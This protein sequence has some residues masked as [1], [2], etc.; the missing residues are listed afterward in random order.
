MAE[1]DLTVCSSASALI[2]T[3]RQRYLLQLRSSD[4][5]IWYAGYWGLF[6]GGI[7]PGETPEQTLRRELKEEL[8]F[9]P[10]ALSYFTQVGIDLR[11]VRGTAVRHTYYE[12]AINEDEVEAMHLGEGDA[13]RLFTAA[14]L[15]DE[16]KI[17]G[18]HS[19]TLLMHIN[20]HRIKQI[21]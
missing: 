14:E 10:K 11:S 8:G 21:G 1:G 18:Y 13:M 7:E 4:A 5:D 12:V 19:L 9:T 6:G 3:N 16:P 2:V 17:V 15:A 20:R